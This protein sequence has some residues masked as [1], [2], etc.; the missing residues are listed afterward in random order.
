[1]KL[2]QEIESVRNYVLKQKNQQTV[3]LV[4]TM[5]ALHNGHLALL[6]A[7]R[8]EN[9]IVICS[10]YVNPTQF[11]DKSDLEKYP[12]NLEKDLEL[13]DEVGCDAVFYPS[14]QIMY[15]LGK[16]QMLKLDF[17]YLDQILEGQYRPGH[18]SGVG[19]VVTKLLN[20]IQPRRAYFGQKDLQQLAIIRRLVQE[21]LIPVEIISVPIVREAS[22]LALSSRN[23][24]LNQEEKQLATQLY[25]SLLLARQL[26]EKG[27]STNQATQQAM[28]Q[29]S[30]YSTIR[31]DYFEAVR[32]SDFRPIQE[33]I[34]QGESIA[35]CVA[36]YVGEVR[37]IDN[38][39][40]PEQNHQ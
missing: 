25:K 23:Q 27:Q 8:E 17:G 10:I 6:K 24:R 14:D 5:G 20:I 15:S 3:G 13:L 33:E 18:F 26:Y 32:L 30:H 40:Y 28:Q 29:L 22:G 4:P 34:G 39:I 12:R 16:D 7:A 37:L 35:F 21:F 2:F 38:I 9:D 11:N 36:A 31:V 1:M 19:L